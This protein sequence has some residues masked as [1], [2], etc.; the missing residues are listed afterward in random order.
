MAAYTAEALDASPVFDLELLMTTS[1]E[2]R[3]GGET[4]DQ[5]SDA[6]DAWVPFAHARKITV[7]N[8]SYLLAWL[9]KK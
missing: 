8:D 1:Q 6:W 5:L 7:G 2:T 4:M 3:L 9:G